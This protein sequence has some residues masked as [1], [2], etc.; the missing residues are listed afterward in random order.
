MYVVVIMC[1]SVSGRKGVQVC[2]RKNMC[3]TEVVCARLC[4]CVCVCVCVFLRDRE[5]DTQCV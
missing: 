3:E 5:R 4:V 1:V 2:V